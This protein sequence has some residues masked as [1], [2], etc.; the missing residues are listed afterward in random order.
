MLPG[1]QFST[2]SFPKTEDDAAACEDVS[3]C[4]SRHTNQENHTVSPEPPTNWRPRALGAFSE[5]RRVG[6]ERSG[7]AMTGQ[8]HCRDR[9]AR[10]APPPA[11][12]PDVPSRS[13][14]C[15]WPSPCLSLHCGPRRR[16][17]P[18]ARTVNHALGRNLLF[19]GCSPLSIGA[20]PP[21]ANSRILRSPGV[22]K[23]SYVKM[24][25]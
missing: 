7:A 22:G 2:F 8:D 4:C 14:R 13:L 24:F 15:F 25:S 19:A 10:P 1:P 5:S 11:R 9:R 23:W 21:P 18:L 12:Y 17:G 20:E 3:T 6:G 16:S